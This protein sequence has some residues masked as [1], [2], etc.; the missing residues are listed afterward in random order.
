MVK[1]IDVMLVSETHLTSRSLF[2]INGYT[3][4][5]TKDPRGRACGGSAILIKSR[6]KHHFLSSICEEYLQATNICIENFSQNFVISSVYSPPRFSITEE[7]YTKFYDSLGNR[8]LAAGD[9]N[10]KHTYW[11]SRLITPKG[12]CLFNAISKMG[13]DVISSGEPTHWPTDSQKIPDVIDFGVTKNITRD[14]VRVEASLDLSS[15][16]SPIIATI[17]NPQSFSAGVYMKTISRINWLKFKK[18]LSTHCSENIRLSTPNDVEMSIDEF[19]K[20]I[21]Q[22]AEHATTIH[23]QNGFNRRYSADI[24]RLVCEKRRA[25]R[26]WQQHRSPQHKTK[27][28]ECTKRLRELLASEKTSS[29]KNYLESLDVTPD[30]KYSLWRAARNLK[31]PVEFK[32]PLRSQRGNWARSDS[33][34][35]NL[36]SDHLKTVFTPNSI[37]DVFD[38][39]SVVALPPYP[40]SFQFRDLQKLVANLNPKKA[41]GIDG[42]TNKML[43]ELPRTALRI[44]LFIFN[45]ILRLE[46]FPTNWKIAS[47][48]M[49]PKPGKDH[50]KAESYR[51]ISLLPT[52]SKL[53]EKLLMSKL[54]PIIAERRCIPD[55][56]FG[57]RRQHSTIQQTHR[58]VQVI[59]NAFE[60]KLFCSALFIDVSQAFDKVWHEGLIMKLRG[61][62]P[63]NIQNLLESYITARKFVVKEGDFISVPKPIASGVPQGSILGPFLYLIYTFDMPISNL[64]HTSTF[65]D[66]TACLSTHKNHHAASQH[67]QEYI[68]QMEQW[69]K[70]W[71]IK[72]NEQK[73]VHVTFTLRKETCPPIFLN[74]QIVPQRSHFKYLGIH[75]DQRLTWKFHIDAKLIQMKLKLS[76]LYW[77]M[78]RNSTLSLDCKLLL[79]KSILKPIWCYGI[80]MWGTASASN[81]EKIQRRQNKILRLITMAPWYIR[82]ANIHRD[83]NM[84]LVSAEIS[85]YAGKYLTKLEFH[86]NPLARNILNYRG[87]IRLKKRDTAALALNT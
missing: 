55:H 48:K 62:L 39:P 84:P 44:M 6:L 87:H 75:L 53:F 2:K 76:E 26:E 73:C 36:F 16:H 67:L 13:L 57:F 85:K 33:E 12:R 52:V 50:T 5:D 49:I 68:L 8:F 61:C 32:P 42:I 30:S 10:A 60:K 80:E 7:Q 72:V 22:A 63:L 28:N 45:A 64:I 40:L 35:G 23:R 43:K 9:Y 19:N 54:S 15:D 58:L 69:L 11:G 71:R 41:P 59:R 37:T 66:D 47:V 51:P 18:Y 24:E 34:K 17:F 86:P 38:L 27:L 83:L 70:L 78:G 14:L 29:L 4:Y 79:Y 56:Q 46:Y 82:N 1:N 81:V 77:L 21:K 3:L 20:K 31:K 25:R 65:A 74:N